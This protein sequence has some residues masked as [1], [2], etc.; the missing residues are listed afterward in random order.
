MAALGIPNYAIREGAFVRKSKKKLNEFIAQI[1][2]INCIMTV[3]A[4]VILI[5]LLMFWPK[6]ISYKKIIV[7][8]SVQIVLTTLG[9]DWINSVFEDYLYLAVRYIVIQIISIV[10]LFLFVKSSSDIYVYTFISMMSN[11]GGNILNW[12]YIKKNG[13]KLRLTTN[14]SLNKHFIPIFI[15]FF[16]CIASTIYLNSDITMLGMYNTDSIVGIYTVSS[17]IYSMLKTLLT[18][19]IMVTLPR[20][21]LY[22]AEKNKVEYKRTLT[23]V[24]DYL[25][26]F[27]LPIAVGLFLEGDKILNIVAGSEYIN[28]DMVVK[29]LA[30]AT[31]FA[32]EACFFTYSILIPNRKEKK[33][34]VST[35]VAALLNIILNI[36]L[37][38]K[39]GIYAAAFTTLIAEF[40]VM[41]ITA[42][43][44]ANV[45]CF[46]FDI[47]IFLQTIIGCIGI[48]CMCI[49]LD[50]TCISDNIKLI[51]EVFI[52]VLVYAVILI[53]LKCDLVI[54]LIYKMNKNKE[55]K[56]KK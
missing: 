48:A 40:V 42:H 36:I 13:V 12:S 30:L 11:A 51:V 26:I 3:V 52:S 43:Y 23:L 21:S 25:I 55:H 8:Q 27:T 15:L 37:L 54:K 4:Y 17:K 33:I 14:V 22:V 34:L 24:Q 50:K 35:V 41:C 47:K 29:I 2:T 32:I 46:D 44:S 53:L 6:L 56:I 9:A 49:L 10:A 31:P 28:G 20:F 19:V 18:S 5:V 16:N 1:F 7:I 39:Y 38:P 45:V